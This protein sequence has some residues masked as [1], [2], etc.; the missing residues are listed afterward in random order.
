MPDQNYFSL[1]EACPKPGC[2]ICRLARCSVDHYLDGL[3]NEMVN[4]VDMR[5][6]VHRMGFCK[7]HTDL[8]LDPRL[9]EPL[10]LTIIYHD[11]LGKIISDLVLASLPKPDT[12]MLTPLSDRLPKNLALQVE[13]SRQALSVHERCPA[14][15]QQDQHTHLIIQSLLENLHDET[16]LVALDGSSGLCLPHLRQALTN[17]QSANQFNRL[18]TTSQS[19]LRALRD[20][21]AEL[22][23]KGDDRFSK[24]GFGE[25]GNAYR[26][27]M[28][29]IVGKLSI[30]DK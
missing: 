11:M 5:Q 4:N 2:P 1:L 9:R 17:I 28:E 12:G 14:C 29:L 23:H 30:E 7:D 3:F 21:L 20:E 15:R 19:K 22:I 24:I 8:L 16:L 26:R 13:S 27:A 25:E 6:Q 18:I 10:G